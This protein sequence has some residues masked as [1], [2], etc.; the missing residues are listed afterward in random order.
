MLGLSTIILA[1]ITTKDFMS[2]PNS[3]VSNLVQ[4]G[5]KFLESRTDFWRQQ[6]PIYARKKEASRLQEKVKAAHKRQDV[7]R[8]EREREKAE[9]VKAAQEVKVV[10]SVP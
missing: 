8:E 3:T 5:L 9:K 6:K 1:Y 2:H 4:E 10:S 7:Q